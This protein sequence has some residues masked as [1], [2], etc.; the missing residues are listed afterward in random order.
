MQCDLSVWQK[1]VPGKSLLRRVHSLLLVL[2]AQPEGFGG[3]TAGL[4]PPACLVILRG[5]LPPTWPGKGQWD[6]S[7]G[8]APKTGQ[9]R[10]HQVLQVFSLL[11]MEIPIHE[12]TAQSGEGKAGFGSVELHP[13]EL[14]ML[15]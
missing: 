3:G 14:K 2:P 8:A 10:V 9:G 15:W 13:Q 7:H 12:V 6:Q 11:R 4:Q 1:Q 5:C